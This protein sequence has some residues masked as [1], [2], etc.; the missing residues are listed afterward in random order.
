MHSPLHILEFITARGKN[1]QKAQ[2]C[3]PHHHPLQRFAPDPPHYTQDW[4]GCRPGIR[5]ARRLRPVLGPNRFILVPP[6]DGPASC[7]LKQGDA[8]AY[9]L[10]RKPSGLPPLSRLRRHQALSKPSQHS[11]PPRGDHY[12]SSP[13]SRRIYYGLFFIRRSSAP[14]MSK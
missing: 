4:A 3:M 14:V 10:P 2:E 12:T 5:L 6:G 13:T 9:A 11:I 1:D 8:A 7:C